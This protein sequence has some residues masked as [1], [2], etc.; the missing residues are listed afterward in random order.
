MRFVREAVALALVA[1]AAI[2]SVPSSVSANMSTEPTLEDPFTGIL[3]LILIN[4][5]TDLFLVSAAVYGATSI[6]KQRVGDISQ[7]PWAFVA[8]VFVAAAVVAVAGGFIDFALLYERVEDH[9]ILK[10]FSVAAIA[11]AAALIFASIAAALR[12]VVGTRLTVSLAAAAAIAPL[13]PLAW[14]VTS[15][16]SAS[17][18]IIWPLMGLAI[19]SAFSAALLLLLHR[20]HGLTFSGALDQAYE[21]CAP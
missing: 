4:F 11:V 1:A 7:D 14:F 8:S 15:A 2:M 12:L 21:G 20:L 6:A 18:V 13:S 16:V 5:S 17:F 3:T 9:Y 10:D 19:T